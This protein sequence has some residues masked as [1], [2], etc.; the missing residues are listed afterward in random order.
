MVWE[1]MAGGGKEPRLVRLEDQ[2]HAE[3]DL[4]GRK[5]IAELEPDSAPP[6]Q[7]YANT[8]SPK[9]CAM[10]ERIR[11]R[12]GLTTLQYQ[13]LGDMVEAIGLPKDKLCTYCWDGAE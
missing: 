2:L 12:L 5:A 7:E 9:Y 6:V 13:E 4:A 10:V 1:R 8:G 11:Q 3:L